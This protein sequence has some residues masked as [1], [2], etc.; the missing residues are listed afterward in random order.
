VRV[1]DDSALG[2]LPEDLG[3]T[4]DRH[5]TRGDDVGQNLPRSDRW[6]LI[7]IATQQQ[8]RALRQGP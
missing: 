7:D 2:G 6:Q 1:G 3:Q 5:G 8:R 4:H